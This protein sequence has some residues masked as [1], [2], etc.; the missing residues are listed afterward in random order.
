MISLIFK[1]FKKNYNIVVLNLRSLL[2]KFFGI[3]KNV[4]D[5]NLTIFNKT[6]AKY[7]IL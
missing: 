5:F 2:N 4:R 3:Q 1:T 6:L 7:Q